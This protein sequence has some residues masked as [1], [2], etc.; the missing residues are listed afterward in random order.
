[1]AASINISFDPD[2]IEVINCVFS[3]LNSTEKL[4]LRQESSLAQTLLT[5]HNTNVFVRITRILHKSNT[6][7]HK[8]FTV[9]EQNLSQSVGSCDAIACPYIFKCS[10]ITS[11]S[12]GILARNNMHLVRRSCIPVYSDTPLLSKQ[13][14]LL[15]SLVAADLLLDLSPL[16][17]CLLNRDY[18]LWM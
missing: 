14:C 6:V 4:R 9:A 15:W 7:F 13:L 5:A 11:G 17:S 10:Y 8:P 18:F 3:I 2:T 12:R 1:M 16:Q